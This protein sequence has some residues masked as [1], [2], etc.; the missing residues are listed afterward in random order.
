MP[1]FEKLEYSVG[2][3]TP[4]FLGDANQQGQW[5]TPPFKALLREWWR[6]GQAGRFNYDVNEM[7]K[8][9]LDLFG[10][11]ASGEGK[12]H[13]SRVRLRLNTWAAGD[14]NVV[15]GRTENHK[16]YN[17][18]FKVDADLYLGYGPVTLNQSRLAI[19][20]DTQNIP[21][22]LTVLIDQA[23]DGERKAIED[24][25]LLASGLG[26]IGSR[27]RN[28]WGS[29]L[30]QRDGQN[31]T[32][33]AMLLKSVSR[34]WKDCLD[35][36]WPHAIGC[37]ENKFLIW[38]TQPKNDWRDVLKDLA[39]LRIKVNTLA[40]DRSVNGPQGRQ[41]LSYPVTRHELNGWG[42]NGR[43]PSQL[44]FKVIPAG[45]QFKGRIVHIPVSIP[46]KMQED[47]KLSSD[48]VLK[49]AIGVWSKVHQELDKRETGLER[50]ALGA[51]R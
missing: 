25:L 33:S 18:R 39:A 36:D 8:A 7:R 29:L 30:L 50:F 32:I 38:H 23:R 28:G 12:S 31:L 6:V 45:N 21:T 24:A 41:I 40:F 51:T 27:S 9:E 20:A 2:F 26:A 49:Q 19:A 44:R 14:E 22:R 1:T 35:L 13:Q 46:T 3:A 48:S 42:G 5:R 37:E 16:V 4:A 15:Q 43:I 34:C 47:A 11:A 10:N 17:G